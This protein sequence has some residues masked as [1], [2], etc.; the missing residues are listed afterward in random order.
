MSTI[1][2]I[3]LIVFAA[4]ATLFF[5]VLTHVLFV[6]FYSHVIDTG[7]DQAYYQAFAERTGP[8]SSIIAGAPIM[9]AICYWAAK[10]FSSGFRLY[11]ALLIW[12]VYFIIDLSIVAAVGQL[13]NIAI[14]FTI[15]FLTKFAAASA[16]G[17]L[18]S[19]K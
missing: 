9:F 3:L 11:A 14:I 19:K 17:F 4:I 7:K 10:K 2:S 13:S 8:Y 16:G 5:N 18:A 15:S 6:V 12:L 1:K